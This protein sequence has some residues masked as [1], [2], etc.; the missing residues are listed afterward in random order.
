[1]YVIFAFLL[2]YTGSLQAQW[3]SYSPVFSDT[4]GAFDLRIAQDN[5]QI[6]WCVAMKYEV[7]PTEYQWLVSEKLSFAKTSDGGNTWSGGTIPMGPEPYASNLCPISANTAWASGIDLDFVNYVLRTDDGG[8]TWTRQLEDGFTGAASYVDFVHFWDAQNGVAVGDPA[9]SD[10][11]PVPFFEIYTTSDGGMTWARVSSADIPLPLANEFGASGIYEVRGDYIWF[12]T[13]DATTFSGKRLFRSK[14]R[15]HHWE[16]LS[17][18]DEKIN[19][20]SFADTLHG[21]GAKR[22]SPTS[23]QI[24]YTTDAGD[25]WTDLPLYVTSEL[26]TSYALIPGSN[27]ILMTRRA[28]NITGPFRTMLSKDLGQSWIELGITENAAALKFSSPT[29]GYAGEWQPADHTTRMY[30][31]AGSPLVGLFSGIELEAQVTLGPNPVSDFL[32]VQI[33]VA[34]PTEFMLLLHD[35]QGR[36]VEQKN[37]EKTAQ[38]MAQFDL[39][40]V[41]AGI[42]MLTVSSENGYLTR[43]VSKI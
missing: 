40:K 7:M 39:S 23:V 5:D 2:A 16:V 31:Y 30:K 22:I 43:S 8:V 21:I 15:G 42:Y 32:K 12:G 14:D 6:A 34:E 9:E 29:V 18:A 1:M 4:L 3:Q 37:I 17:A 24:I 11:N 20:F 26:A 33:E 27:Y 10:T 38:G 35:S 28:D 41:P 25:S 19:I 13:I 36:L